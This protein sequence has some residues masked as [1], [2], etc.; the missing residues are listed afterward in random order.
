MSD[1][2]NKFLDESPYQLEDINKMKPIPYIKHVRRIT[3]MQNEMDKL[4]SDLDDVKEGKGYISQEH[5]EQILKEQLE[6]Q[7]QI[8]REKTDSIAKLRNTEDA[9]REKLLAQ[10][11]QFEE[12]KKQYEKT[13]DLI[14]KNN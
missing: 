4:Y 11:K 10:Q 9:L 1:S 14:S 13:I 8:I 5:H 3:M 7:Q 6:K 2:F 12:D